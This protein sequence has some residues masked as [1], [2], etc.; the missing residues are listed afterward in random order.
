MARTLAEWLEYQQTLMPTGMQLG[1]ER[2]RPVARSLGLRAPAR[3]T[4]SVGGTN[5]K[6]STVAF[7]ES[8]A[9]ASGWRVAAYTSPHLLRYEERLRIDGREVESARL[10]AA[11]DRI[12][13]ARGST[14]LTYFEFGTLAAL[15]I[16][17]ESALDLALLEVGLGGRLDAVNLVDADVAVLTTVALDH[18]EYLGPDR[19]AIGIEKS[20]IFRP[21]RPAVLGETLP[22]LSVLQA[23]DRIGA[24]AV[25][26]GLG[27]KVTPQREGSWRYEDSFGTLELPPPALIAGCQISNAAA[28]LAALRHL[29]GAPALPPGAVAEGLLSVRLPGRMQRLPGPVEVLLDVAHNPQAAQ[30][31]ARWLA[32][33]KPNGTTQAVFSALADKDIPSVVAPLMGVVDVWRFAGLPG[34]PGRGL[35][36]DAL[37]RTVAGLLPR[38]LNTRHATVADALTEALTCAEP[39]DRV[40]VFGSFHTVA[41]ALQA[42][43]SDA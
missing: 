16:M 31:L 1:L 25:R 5:G 15:L 30:E 43:G 35:E 39:G 3:W 11:F 13:T 29:P 6:G 9:R 27:F 42:M 23:I 4:I 34:V 22:P 26:A 28:A 20:G 40:V 18:V 41:E 33:N 19:E 32:G 24:V 2:V 14:P 36:V 12:E 38:G 8:I 21:S 7:A 17:S 37:W 10:V